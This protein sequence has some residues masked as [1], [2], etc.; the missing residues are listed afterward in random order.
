MPFDASASA[1]VFALAALVRADNG[2]NQDNQDN[3]KTMI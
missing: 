2:N 3:I 1:Q